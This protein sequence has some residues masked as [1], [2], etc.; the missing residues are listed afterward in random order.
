MLQRL[1]LRTGSFAVVVGLAVGILWQTS[2]PGASLAQDITAGGSAT[3]LSKDGDT[4]KVG[5]AFGEVSWDL[6]LSNENFVQLSALGGF[7][8]KGQGF[9]GIGGRHYWLASDG[10]YPAIGAQVFYLNGD[11]LGLDETSIFLGPELS[12]ELLSEAYP[13]SVRPFV[14]WYPAISGDDASLFRFGLSVNDIGEAVE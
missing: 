5:D 2:M 7:G 12:I 4:N 14:A 11:D 9:L 3:F 8:E 1:A 6:A 13:W 10:F